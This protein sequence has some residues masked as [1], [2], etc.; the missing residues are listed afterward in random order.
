[1]SLGNVSYQNVGEVCSK[2]RIRHQSGRATQSVK[3]CS[4][5]RPIPRQDFTTSSS[6]A[7][8]QFL[9]VAGDRY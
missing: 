1:M 5:F 6:R 7:E 8:C 4:V 9:G 3:R 2:G